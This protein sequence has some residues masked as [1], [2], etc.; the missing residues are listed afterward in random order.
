MTH[1]IRILLV[2]ALL[3]HALWA[4]NFSTIQMKPFG[5]DQDGREATLYTLKNENGMTAE[6]TNYGGIVTR[7][8][9]PDRN[10]HFEDIVLGYNTIDEYLEATPYFGALIGRVGNRIADG[11]FS[12][13]GEDYSL[14]TNNAP[15]GIPCHLHG[16]TRGF[17]KVLWD[18][19]AYIENNESKLKLKYTSVDGEEGYPGTLEVTVTYTLTNANELKIEYHAVTDK[20]TPVNLTNHSYFNLR[21][22]GNGDILDHIVTL[23]ADNMTPVDAGLIPTG[24]ITP[25]AGTP[26]DFTQPTAI[27]DRVDADDEQIAYGGGYDHNWV[28]NKRGQG[29]TLAATVYEPESGRYMEVLTEEPGVQFYVGNFLDG[30]NVGKKGIAYQKRTGFCLETQHYPDSINQ[31][32]FPSIVLEPGEVYETTTIYKFTAR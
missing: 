5:N 27:G 3:A 32:N 22:E 10:G 13:N 23:N 17:D 4:G 15:G 11:K 24:E 30:T 8:F 26:F 31:P 25:V 21:G 18:A 14:V 19:K 9:A 2:K 7:L 1:L 16:G 28:L 6:I 20:A 12:L 29:M